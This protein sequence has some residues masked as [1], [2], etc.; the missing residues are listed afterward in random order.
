MYLRAMVQTCSQCQFQA[1]SW[2]DNCPRC[3]LLLSRP[4][5]VRALGWAMMVLGAGLVV[6]MAYLIVAIARIIAQSDDPDATSRF[7]GT[8]AQALMVYGIL[9]LV[10]V[11]G[12]VSVVAGAWQVR[13]GTRNPRLVKL[14]LGLAAVFMG[15]GVLVQ[16]LA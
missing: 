3:G 8:P 14:V 11:F 4:S 15:I 5:R 10:L 6:G 1:Q 7:A 2:V 16:A 9:G 12:V 13:Y